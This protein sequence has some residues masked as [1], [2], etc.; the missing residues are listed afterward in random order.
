MCGKVGKRAWIALALMLGGIFT[1]GVHGNGY[2]VADQGARA[3]GQANAFAAQADDASAIYYNPAG[4]TQVR[5]TQLTGGSYFFFPDVH[6]SGES[7]A[8]ERMT[9]WAPIPHF[10]AASGFGTDRWRFGLGVNN[11]F[12]LDEDW[13]D[14]SF[15]TLVTKAHLY[16]INIAPT[17]A[18]RVNDHL[19]LGAELNVYYAD[20][21]LNRRVPLGPPPMPEATYHLEGQGVSAGATFGA[22]YKFNERHTLAAVYRSPFSVRLDGEAELEGLASSDADAHIKF[23][24]MAILAYAFRPTQRW[25]LETDIEFTNW[26]TFDAIRIDADNPALSGSIPTEWLDSMTYRF[27]TQYDLDRH[28]AVRAGYAFGQSSTPESTY[29]PLLPDSNFHSFCAGLGYSQK[30][31]SL[32]LAYQYILRERTIIHDSINSPLVNG[33]WENQSHA[34]A[35]TL[36]IRF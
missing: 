33:T 19:S 31:W 25:K 28:W 21:E 24:E 12:G 23:P 30:A 15:R 7:G 1:K 2:E 20:A 29:S 6:F 8:D 32:D 22:M 14:E 17:V 3:I 35:L 13:G 26:E 10:Y 11:V 36:T 18:V 16:V 27:G 9:Q 34:V 4:L 5:G